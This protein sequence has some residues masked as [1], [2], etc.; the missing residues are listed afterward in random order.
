[1][2]Q[3]LL[4]EAKV[5]I[6]ATRCK[7]IS[8]HFCRRKRVKVSSISKEHFCSSFHRWWIREASYCAV[9]FEVLGHRGITWLSCNHWKP[10]KTTA[11]GAYCY[12]HM[13]TAVAAGLHFISQQIMIMNLGYASYV[14][15]FPIFAEREW[16]EILTWLDSQFPFNTLISEY[17]SFLLNAANCSSTGGRRLWPVSI[18]FAG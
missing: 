15:S 7:I 6:F 14:S 17:D 8:R 9:W 5:Q 10:L 2:V 4:P 1:M 11:S 12:C 16:T 13:W 18:T 3:N